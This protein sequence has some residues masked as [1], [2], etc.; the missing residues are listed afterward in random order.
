MVIGPSKK[1][2]TQLQKLF[3][4]NKKQLAWYLLPGPWIRWPWWTCRRRSTSPGATTS[5]PGWSRRRLRWWRCCGTGTCCSLSPLWKWVKCI[6][7]SCSRFFVR[8]KCFFLLFDIPLSKNIPFILTQKG[9]KHWKAWKIKRRKGSMEK[10]SLTTLSTAWYFLK[11]DIMNL[12]L[13]QIS[14][15]VAKFCHIRCD[16]EKSIG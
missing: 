14:T 8:K 9:Q 7:M 3:Y 2:S 4:L 13:P 1:D 10:H 16:R 12:S 6:N 15:S 5:V 11:T